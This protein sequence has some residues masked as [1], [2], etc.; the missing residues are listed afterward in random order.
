MEDCP[1]GTGGA[2]RLAIPHVS[3]D[4]VL[5]TNGDSFIEVD[6]AEYIQWFCAKQRRAA[7]LLTEVSDSGRY[8]R[9]RINEQDVIESFEEKCDTP[10]AGLIN[11][12]MYLMRKE[13]IASIPE[14][15]FYSLEHQLFP[16]LA[17][18]SLFGFRCY[19]RFI[20]IGTPQSYEMAKDFFAVKNPDCKETLGI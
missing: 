16:R 6:I 13:L 14:G 5:I 20:D 12:G 15:Q 17:G 1:L 9:V 10:R 19:G 4:I 8:G 7:L 11:T 18:A 2:L 3:S